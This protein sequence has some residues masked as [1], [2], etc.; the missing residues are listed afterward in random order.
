MTPKAII[1]LSLGVLYFAVTGFLSSRANDTPHNEPFNPLSR[2]ILWSMII[3]AFLSA[4]VA[5]VFHPYAIGAGEVLMIEFVGAMLSIIVFGKNTPEETHATKERPM[6]DDLFRAKF[7]QELHRLTGADPATVTDDTKLIDICPASVH[8]S[9][10]IG[11]INLYM[12]KDGGMVICNNS[13]TMTI[14]NVLE[15]MRTSEPS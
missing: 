6:S 12:G 14:G 5:Q 8:I 10:L 11:M 15:Q 13:N 4:S 1:F 9:T 2:A 3:F 7:L